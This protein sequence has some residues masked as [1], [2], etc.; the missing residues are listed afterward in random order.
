MGQQVRVTLILAGGGL[1]PELKCEPGPPGVERSIGQLT[2]GSKSA[3]P[4]DLRE[5]AMKTVFD[6]PQPVRR[7]GPMLLPAG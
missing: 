7:R 3:W 2:T 6:T 1:E 4:D 5:T